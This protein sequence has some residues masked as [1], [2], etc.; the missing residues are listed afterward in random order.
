MRSGALAALGRTE[1]AKVSVA[2]ALRRFPNLTVEGFVNQPVFNEAERQRL[3]K[4]MLVVGF[5]NCAKAEE[6]A[7]IEKPLRLP[8][9]ASL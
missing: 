5:P 3:V 4:A 7:K 2:E 6:L 9:C 8:K 1:E